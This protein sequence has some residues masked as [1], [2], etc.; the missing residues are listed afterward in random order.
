M[1]N[2]LAIARNQTAGVLAIYKVVMAQWFE[3][4]R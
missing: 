2:I 4:G 3:H 1:S